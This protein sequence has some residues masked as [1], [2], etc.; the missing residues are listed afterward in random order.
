MLISDLISTSSGEVCLQ[1][2]S[3][4]GNFTETTVE[5]LEERTGHLCWDIG[6][7][8]GEILLMGGSGSGVTT[9]LVKH[10]GSD[11]RASFNLTHYT[12]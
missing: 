11:T 8:G 9:E 6:G 5:L 3:L 2:D 1:T 10:D 12:E 4:D 7:P